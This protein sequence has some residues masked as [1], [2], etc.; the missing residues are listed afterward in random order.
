VRNPGSLSKESR[1]EGLPSLQCPRLETLTI[2]G[3]IEY[4]GDF[5]AS[6]LPIRR[7]TYAPD[8][9]IAGTLARIVDSPLVARLEE[10][11]IG[12]KDPEAARDAV[13]AAAPRLAHLRR[14][15]VEGLT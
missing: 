3:S 13:A 4:L 15:A 12:G 11:V 10:L 9:P 14:F 1:V 8:E 7:W 6:R 2:R 5:L